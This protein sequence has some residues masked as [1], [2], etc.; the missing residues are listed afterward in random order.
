MR[1]RWDTGSLSVSTICVASEPSSDVS[2]QALS[3]SASKEQFARDLGAHE[4]VDG[5]KQDHAEA[6]QKLGGAALIIATAA[7]PKLIGGLVGGLAP[8]GKLLVLSRKSHPIFNLEDI[9][10]ILLLQRF[11]KS[12]FQSA[13]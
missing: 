11:L 5:S 8:Q 3:S 9:F 6:L 7:N 4:Y 2:P 12:L 13:P 10:L 1:P